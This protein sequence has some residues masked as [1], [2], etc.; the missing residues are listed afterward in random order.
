MTCDH[1][2]HDDDKRKKK[3]KDDGRVM[4]QGRI[5]IWLCF[6]RERERRGT[7]QE[8]LQ[9]KSGLETGLRVAND[10]ETDKKE[11]T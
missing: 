9:W 11:D 8:R 1:G 6:A 3:E 5:E 7:L 2:L 10:E 4:V